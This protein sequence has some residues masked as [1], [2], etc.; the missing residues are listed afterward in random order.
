M[1]AHAIVKIETLRELIAAGA[2]RSA[3]LL[4]QRG[5]YA[6]LVRAGMAERYLA[7]K[8]GTVKLYA[9]L[10]TAAKDLR[11]LGLAEFGVNV[12]NFEPG[13]LRPARPDRVTGLKRAHQLAAHDAW[14]REQVQQTLAKVERGEGALLSHD[15][16]I[17][18]LRAHAAERDAQGAAAARKG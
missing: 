1:P 15:E 13:R 17:T 9:R 18:R 7:N 4:G 5:G 10:D 12:V 11:E 8:A 16:V 3:T 6:V 14:F 2:V